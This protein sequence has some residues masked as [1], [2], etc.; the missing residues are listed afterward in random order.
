VDRRT[1]LLPIAVAVTAAAASAI[2]EECLSPG[3]SLGAG[4]SG[5]LAVGVMTG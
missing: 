1:R 2:R 5:A 4:G 3:L